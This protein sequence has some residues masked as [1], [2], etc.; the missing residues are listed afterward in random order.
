VT[1]FADHITREGI[2]AVAYSRDP[3]STIYALL[4]T[5]EM[6]MCTYDRLQE[7]TAWSRW[8]TNG[9]VYSMCGLRDESTTSVWIAVNRN[10]TTCIEYIPSFD[11]ETPFFLDCATVS[12]P[13]VVTISTV[14]YAR[15]PVSATTL[16]GDL[17]DVVVDG[18]HLGQGVV[19]GVVSGKVDVP[20]PTGD[21]V[22]GA[23]GIIY[24]Q[25]KCVSLP[26]NEGVMYGTA[27]GRVKSRNE[28]FLRMTTQ[29]M[30]LVNGS[31]VQLP[32]FTWSADPTDRNYATDFRTANIGWDRYARFDIE[33]DEPLQTDVCCVFGDADVSQL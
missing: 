18:V 7:V 33:V 13:E 32:P 8:V 5:G 10:G 23:A 15:L 1:F 31:R 30:P 9:T 20:Y 2:T 21:G 17:V 24:P 4:T 16:D 3:D 26:L 14:R 27:Q 28:I 25:V 11:A 12:V 29:T 6:R 22:Q 19:G